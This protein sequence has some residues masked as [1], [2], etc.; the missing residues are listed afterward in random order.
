MDRIGKSI[1]P[2]PLMV[3][4]DENGNLNEFNGRPKFDKDMGEWRIDEEHHDESELDP[5]SYSGL[6]PKD[7]P[8]AKFITKEI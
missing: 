1:V 8:M 7:G 4:R 5:Q 6:Q 2:Q 3:G